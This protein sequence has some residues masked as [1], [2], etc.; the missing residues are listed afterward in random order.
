MIDGVVCR[1]GGHDWVV[2]P[3]NLRQVR[4][5]QPLLEK[6]GGVSVSSGAEQIESIVRVV[7]T[8]LARNY[9][10]VTEDQ[11]EQMLDLGNANPIVMAVMGISGLVSRGEAQEGSRSGGETSTDASPRPQDGPGHKSTT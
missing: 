9:P 1:M 5:L 10:D 3:L 8:A 11:V 2:P 4:S 7:W 6:L